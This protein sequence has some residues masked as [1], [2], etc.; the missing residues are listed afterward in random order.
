MPVAPGVH[1]CGLLCLMG[2][3]LQLCDLPLD[4][5]WSAPTSPIHVVALVIWGLA[6]IVLTGG[7]IGIITHRFVPPG[8]AAIAGAGFTLLGN[9]C[10]VG[11]MICYLLLPAL[12]EGRC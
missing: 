4:L 7:P 9:L 5:W 2:G 1:L 3:S 11:G 6:N 10:Q 8:W 12:L